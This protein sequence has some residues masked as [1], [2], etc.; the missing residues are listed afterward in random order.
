MEILKNF[1]IDPILLIAGIVNFLIILFILKKLVY[2]PVF[3]IL[4]KRA[5]G[6]K[7][8]IAQAE[9]SQK[10][11]KDAETKEKKII[12]EAQETAKKI[13]QDAK[14]QALV[15]GK[16]IEEKAKK[17][18]DQMIEDAK[19]QIEIETKK[20]EQQLN[21]HISELSIEILKKSL[22]STF[23]SKEQSEIVSKAVKT[24]KNEAN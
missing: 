8:G 16:N 18:S 24:I 13:I 11:L 3:N 20:A 12:K 7:E 23:G 22:G 10:A 4:Q 2:K 5:D 17:Q 19:V 14:E 21:K 6:I 1:G 9:E 15:V